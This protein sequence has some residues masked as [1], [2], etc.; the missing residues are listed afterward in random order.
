[1]RAAAPSTWAIP[2]PIDR[3]NTGLTLSAISAFKGYFTT[4]TL[5]YLVYIRVTK[6]IKNSTSSSTFYDPKPDV[7]CPND[8]V[9]TEDEAPAPDPELYRSITSSI[10]H[11]AVWTR[12]DISYIVNKLCQFNHNPSEI[13]AKSAKHL[14]RYI[15]RTLDYGITY[16]HGEG[17]TLYGMFM[18]YDDNSLSTTRHGSRVQKLAIT[19]ESSRVELGFF[20]SKL[21]LESSRV[22]SLESSS[23]RVRLELLE[24]SSSWTSTRTR[25]DSKN[26]RPM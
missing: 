15:A 1:L 26:S 4:G 19:R 3:G 8:D 9:R 20:N 14:L 5:R 18:D 16:S 24:S 25:L 6:L 11:R 2:L 13:H 12:P 17:N 22:S 7:P 23:S 21:E 10:M